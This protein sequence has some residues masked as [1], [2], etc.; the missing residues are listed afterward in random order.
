[1]ADRSREARPPSRRKSSRTCEGGGEVGGKEGRD[2]VRG[3][4]VCVVGGVG[5]WG[6]NRRMGLGIGGVEASKGLVPGGR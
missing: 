4:S 1:M 2:G 6:E 5:G 3:K